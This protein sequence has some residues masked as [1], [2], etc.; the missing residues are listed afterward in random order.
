MTYFINPNT[1]NTQWWR[2]KR[3]TTIKNSLLEKER[4]ENNMLSSIAYTLAACMDGARA[5]QRE[6]TRT[7]LPSDGGRS[8]AYQSSLPWFSFLAGA[9]LSVDPMTISSDGCGVALL[10]Q[11]SSLP[12]LSGT[13]LGVHH[14]LSLVWLH[15]FQA[16]QLSKTLISSWLMCTQSSTSQKC[17]SKVMTI[18]NPSQNSGP[19]NLDSCL[20]VPVLSSR[21][22]SSTHHATTHGGGRHG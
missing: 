11:G 22:S 7:H 5:W 19:L 9:P 1:Y 21:P 13:T 20:K 12:H 18:C 15:V 4:R 16:P 2:K 17:G 14:R 8:L 6:I 3:V 10:T